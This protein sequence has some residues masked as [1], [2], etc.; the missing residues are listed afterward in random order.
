M[1][2]AIAGCGE[3]GAS[4]EP[5][6]PEDP[7]RPTAPLH[8]RPSVQSDQGA[9]PLLRTTVARGFVRPVAL[10]RDPDDP[11]RVLVVEQSGTARWL[12][13]ARP[14]AGVPFMDLRAT[15][16]FK[17]ERGLL[18]AAFLPGYARNPRIAVHYTDADSRNRVVVYRVV[19]GVVDPLSAEELLTLEQPYGNHNGGQLAVGPDDRLYVGIGDGGSAYDPRENGQ[20]LES[21]FGKVLRYDLSDGVEPPAALTGPDGTTDDL[22][23]RIA[24][25]TEASNGRWQMVGYGLRDPW[26]LTFDRR[27]GDL[28]IADVGL[29]RAQRQTQE[30]DRISAERLRDPKPPANFG[31]AGF[32]GVR[33]QANR[34][35]TVQ[36]PLSWPEASFV[37]ER[38]CGITGGIVVR[39][40]RSPFDGRYLFGDQCSGQIWSVPTSGRTPRVMRN[41]RVRVRNLTAML[42]EDDGGFLV[43]SGGGGIFRVTPERGTATR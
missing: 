5:A 18:G 15:V 24:A 32:D 26:R 25:R 12:D 11:D 40:E 41:E 13:G 30:A 14:A 21:L 33:D 8:G 20:N 9:Q 36:G 31:W 35:L 37:P 22:D 10:L 17:D 34:Q 39:R 43:A 16:E 19:D 38:G 6:A 4:T 29:D 3:T 27:T 42:A 1:A 7:P 28:W 23:K 2:V